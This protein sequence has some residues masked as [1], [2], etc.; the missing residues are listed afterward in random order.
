MSATGAMN[1]HARTPKRKAPRV[2]EPVSRRTSV[3]VSTAAASNMTGRTTKW[4]ASSGAAPKTVMT[5]ASSH[6]SPQWYQV[7]AGRPSM[8]E[9]PDGG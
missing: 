9:N 8:S 5:A 2:R 1:R 7:C 6:I 3:P 4:R